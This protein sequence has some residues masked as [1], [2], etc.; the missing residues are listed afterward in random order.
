MIGLWLVA[1]AALAADLS[2]EVRARGTGDPIAGADVQLPD[3][4]HVVTDPDGR[5]SA[6]LPAGPHVL[7][8][9]APGWQSGDL[10]VEMPHSGVAQVWLRPAPVTLEIVVEAKAESPHKSR[11]V[12]DR[13]RVEKVPGAFD[14]PFR[15]AQSLPGV[16]STPEYSPTS[17]ALVLRGA[18]PG[19]SRVFLDG[20][21]LPYLYHFQQYAS[22]VHSRLLE[23]LAIYPSAFGASWGDAVGG[24]AA[25]RTRRP[26]PV[27]THGGVNLNTI[28]GG[29]WVQ[30][31]LKGGR[32]VSLSGR[33][34]FADLFDSSNDQ[35]T[36]W[37]VFWDYM[38]GAEQRLD[39]GGRLGITLLGAGDSY[40]RYVGDTGLLD[41]VGRDQAP[42]FRFSRAFHGAIASSELNGA[43]SSHQSTL[44]LTHD[45]WG[46]E[47][48]GG[49]QD[50]RA[51]QTVARHTSR[52]L[53]TDWLSVATGGDGTVNTVQR[54]VQV[55]QAWL[56]LAAEVPLMAHGVDIRDQWS[57]VR[58]G[59]WVEPQVKL[60][61]VE[62]QPGL[63]LQGDSLVQA[64]A[65]EPRIG[66]EADLGESVQLHAAGGRHTQAPEVDAVARA[67]DALDLI[68][69]WQAVAGVNWAVAGRWELG[70]EG[71]GRTLT[72]A[73]VDKAGAPVQTVSGQAG[74]VELT[75]RY[76]LRDLFFAYAS[77][78][79]ARSVRGG[80]PA[81]YDQPL[82]VNLVGSWDFAEGWNAGLRYRY[83]SGL[84]YSPLD[85]LYSADTDTWAPVPKAPNAARLPDY[86]KV[87]VHLERAWA[88][89]QWTLTGYLEAWWVPS[90]SNAMY[91]VHSYDYSESAAVAGPPFLPLMGL[92]ADL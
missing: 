30:A 2:G 38:G 71:W 32:A 73:V 18:A 22:V 89:K 13:E 20:V 60:G 27:R 53:V 59:V 66:A 37:P 64:S 81:D 10:S 78:S 1:S 14:D 68:D 31:P 76:R 33:R 55:D 92:R 58:G 8:V 47:L 24:V 7:P 74:G 48:T 82:I 12:L 3:G 84:P 17:G 44:G 21:E 69:S 43:T 45:R 61:P 46:G 56:E 49:M 6:V 5:F 88:F 91:V 63:R 39:S 51:L 50:R 57:R 19:E 4:T 79:L 28:T 70:V 67:T 15:L 90:G 52:F 83:A 85:G 36:S 75:T 62:L 26:D 42:D 11:Q 72:G 65:V 34:S 23:E 80:A 54:D 87:D 77:V 25:V 9:S 29:A 41:P 86:Q 40:G 35:Y 16:A